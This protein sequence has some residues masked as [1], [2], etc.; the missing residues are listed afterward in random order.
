MSSIRNVTRS[1]GLRR[2]ARTAAAGGA[3][4]V[5][6]LTTG[7]AVPSTAHAAARTLVASDEFTGSWGQPANPSIW[8]ALQ[9]GGGWGNH[10]LQS[11]TA[12]QSNVRL[13]GTGALEIVA[14][15]ESY[16]GS[17]GVSS[18]YTSGRLITSQSILY[19]YIEARIQLP[20]GQGM[21]PAFWTL[22]ADV[23][24]GVPWPTTGEI[25]I[26][27]ATNAMPSATGTIHG[28]KST[29]GNYQAQVK[30]TPPTSLAGGWHT[31]GIDWTST[32][33]TWY[34]DGQ[35]YGTITKAGLPAADVW[36]FAKPQLLQLNL[37]VGGDMPGA[38]DVST[39][40]P[41][42]MLVDYVRVYAN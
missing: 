19:G 9:G 10:E 12:R 27:E 15:K 30:V 24:Q 17:D 16:T 39:T 40:L 29:G 23:Y 38:P 20:A 41:A 5:V 28:P 37:A 36:E 4:I 6:Q 26:V 7:G 42:S 35:A 31:Y 34:L 3:L 21:W 13:N 22:G 32:A 14:R 2:L 11:Y 1:V 8:T 25:D 33:I 18:A